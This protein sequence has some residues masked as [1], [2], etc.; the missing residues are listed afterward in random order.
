MYGR[1][2]FALYPISELGVLWLQATIT[3]ALCWL[4]VRT[5]LMPVIVASA[6]VYT[7]TILLWLTLVELDVPTLWDLQL[8]GRGYPVLALG[9][10]GFAIAFF[11]LKT[12]QR[13][14]VRRDAKARAADRAAVEAIAPGPAE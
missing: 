12:L 10:A 3:V 9:G 11:V 5:K 8:A 14:Q 6:A 13:R 2:T 1:M 4:V 7:G